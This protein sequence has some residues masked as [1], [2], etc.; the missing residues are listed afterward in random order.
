MIKN[1]FCI[2]VFSLSM[3]F[4]QSS[5]ISFYG[6]GEYLNTYDASS[7][8][9]GDGIY[10]GENSNGFSLQSLSSHWKSESTNLA[11]SLKFSNNHLNLHA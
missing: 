9:K 1:I 6:M 4:S 7:I 5:S 11:L 2:I 10:F 3:I 8:S